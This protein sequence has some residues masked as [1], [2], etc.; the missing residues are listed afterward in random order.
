V[1]ALLGRDCLSD[2]G[3]HKGCPYPI[4]SCELFDMDINERIDSIRTR[5]DLASFVRFLHKDLSQ[6][7][8]Q[9]E[10]PTLERYLEAM[11]A[12]LADAEGYFRNRDDQP[13][14]APTWKLVAEILWASAIY[15]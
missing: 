2:Q 1:D 10:N 4:A 15:E 7:G 9:W 14:G 8:D 12:W 5:E 6:H 11:S 13:P 3:T